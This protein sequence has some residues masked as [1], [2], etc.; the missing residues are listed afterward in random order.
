MLNLW[1]CL[2][3]TGAVLL[4]HRF[5]WIILDLLMWLAISSSKNNIYVNY[6]RETIKKNVNYFRESL[7]CFCGSN[8]CHFPVEQ[9]FMKLVI[10][11]LSSILG[12]IVW[13]FFSYFDTAKLARLKQA[14]EEAEKEVA[15]YRSHM[16]AAFQS[17]LA[18]VSTISTLGKFLPCICIWTQDYLLAWKKMHQCFGQIG[19]K[20]HLIL[21]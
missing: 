16:E 1:Y 4:L 20:V 17:K 6:F 8:L 3:G 21:Q 11:P 10:W 5:R 13:C 15:E 2:M 9:S 19:L 18:E 12:L 7:S 14:K